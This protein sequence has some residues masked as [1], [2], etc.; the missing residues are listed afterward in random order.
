MSN[1]NIW[2][3]IFEEVTKLREEREREQLANHEKLLPGAELLVK[4]L[5]R[6]QIDAKPEVRKI[7]L[8]IGHF[9]RCGVRIGRYFITI[10]QKGWGDTMS[11]STG[12]LMLDTDYEDVNKAI[13]S[14]EYFPLYGVDTSGSA[15]SCRFVE[16]IDNLNIEALV[17]RIE[18][19]NEALDK[20]NSAPMRETKMSP[21]EAIVSDLIDMIVQ[22]VISNVD[23]SELLD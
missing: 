6:Y 12:S 22:E 5:K 14:R 15:L 17:E 18:E 2:G 20:L 1:E 8:P 7:E 3:T 11:W 23:I 21:I 10:H 4:N 13:K 19:L 9:Y 16:D